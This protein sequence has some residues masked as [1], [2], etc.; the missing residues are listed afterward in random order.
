MNPRPAAGVVAV[1]FILCSCAGT[2]AE[3]NRKFLSGSEARKGIV[4]FS[5]TKTGQ[6]RNM[7][8]GTL[9]FTCDS[10]AKGEVDD[11]YAMAQY[12]DGQRPP[13]PVGNPDVQPDHPMGRIHI[14]ELP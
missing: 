3:L 9:S 6:Y 11:H 14:L 7:L 1:A 8:S 4:V 5:T 2:V 12:I 10:G 13:I